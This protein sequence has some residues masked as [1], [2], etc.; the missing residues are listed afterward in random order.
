MEARI[1]F[2]KK[3]ALRRMVKAGILNEGEGEKESGYNYTS[4]GVA[5]V[6]RENGNP[7]VYVKFNDMVNLEVHRIFKGL[8]ILKVTIY[9]T[10]LKEENHHIKQGTDSMGKA[11][12]SVTYAD[13][14][15][16]V[17]TACIHSSAYAYRSVITIRVGSVNIQSAVDCYK[18]IREGQSSEKW[19]G[20]NGIPSHCGLSQT[21]DS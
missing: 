7:E 4:L 16:E 20:D 1:Y 13:K 2:N 3:S 15:F 9:D 21:L 12:Y 11:V 10:I 18:K 6:I 17:P 14:K 5:T 19:K 8:K